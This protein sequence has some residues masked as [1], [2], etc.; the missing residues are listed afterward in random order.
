MAI[1]YDEIRITT[2]REINVCEGAIRKLE[3]QIGAMEKKHKTT[4]ADFLR[5][6]YPLATPPKGE[7]TRWHDSCYALE[8]WKERL[9][10]HRQIMKIYA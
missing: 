5:E 4:S 10:A 2:R 3:K 9:S 6:F 7:L 8:R 1:E